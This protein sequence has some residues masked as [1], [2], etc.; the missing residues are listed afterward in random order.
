MTSFLLFCFGVTRITTPTNLLLVLVFYY[1]FIT[2]YS[3]SLLLI[4]TIY[5]YLLKSASPTLIYKTFDINV[6]L[7]CY[8]T[9]KLE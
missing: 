7:F 1:Y 4:S 2:I 5:Y 3:T 9:L 6:G 8:S